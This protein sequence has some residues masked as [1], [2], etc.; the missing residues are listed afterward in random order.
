[1]KNLIIIEELRSL[2]PAPTEEEKSLLEK[3]ILEEGCREALIVWKKSEEEFI[4]VDGHNRY[5]ICTKHS[6]NFKTTEKHFEDMESVKDWM[7]ANQLSRRNLTELQKSFLRGLQYKQEKKKTKN[8]QNLIQFQDSAPDSNG[9]TEDAN[10]ASSVETQKTDTSEKLAE[11]HNV[12]SRTIKYDEKFVDG[13]EAITSMLPNQE[14]E[15]VKQD[16]LKGIIPLPKETIKDISKIDDEI[17]KE[18]IV[19]DIEALGHI[20]NKNEKKEQVKQINN[21]VKNATGSGSKKTNFDT[22]GD[23]KGLT[24]DITAKVLED[25]KRVD[26]IAYKEPLTDEQNQRND[27]ITILSRVK[28]LSSLQ[29]I[30]DFIMIT[31]AEEQEMKRQMK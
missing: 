31:I 1:M 5:D 28:A 16:I 13:L 9:L 26:D 7:I 27:I 20:T 23:I 8:E 22:K 11:E 19:K 17:Q 12:S 14:G 30:H 24:K 29:K 4:L 15:K 25:S 21:K 6:I 10:F 2:I 18:D 3:S